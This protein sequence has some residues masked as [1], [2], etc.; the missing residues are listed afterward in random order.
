M[1]I[2]WAAVMIYE[3]ISSLFFMDWTRA[4]STAAK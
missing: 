3:T 2:T 4:K 1:G